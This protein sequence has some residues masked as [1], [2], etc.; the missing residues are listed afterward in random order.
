[1]GSQRQG[2]PPPPEGP[3]DAA[4]FDC[5]ALCDEGQP[6]ARRRRQAA[7]LARGLSLTLGGCGTSVTVPDTVTEVLRVEQRNDL[8]A[9]PVHALLEALAVVVEVHD[10][11]VA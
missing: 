9:E 3:G 5:K 7:A 8:R 10:E 6:P 2:S 4:R 11:T 1:M